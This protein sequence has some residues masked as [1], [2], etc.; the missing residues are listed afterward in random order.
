MTKKQSKK[1]KIMS[2]EGEDEIEFAEPTSRGGRVLRPARLKAA[3]YKPHEVDSKG[4]VRSWKA[5]DGRILSKYR[6]YREI[7]LPQLNRR[8]WRRINDFEG[9]ARAV[10]LRRR[11]F[12][13]R[14]DP[15]L[16]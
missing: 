1:L 16:Y 10:Q 4:R 15:E 5:P 9:R 2:G 12:V 3:G 14:R 13:L 8:E 7:N 11:G 6:A